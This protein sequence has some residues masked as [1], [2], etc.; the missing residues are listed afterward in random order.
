MTQ[1]F[2]LKLHNPQQSE[3]TDLNHL[4]LSCQLCYVQWVCCNCWCIINIIMVYNTLLLHVTRVRLTRE[5]LAQEVNMWSDHHVAA[6]FGY[7]YNSKVQMSLWKPN[8]LC[9]M[10]DCGPSPPCS[11]SLQTC[12][13]FSVPTCVSVSDWV[14]LT[15]C[16]S[17]RASSVSGKYLTGQVAKSTRRQIE[18]RPA[19]EWEGGGELGSGR[20]RK[21]QQC[22]VK[23]KTETDNRA[24]ISQRRQR[25]SKRDCW[26]VQFDKMLRRRSLSFGGF[27]WY[28]AFFVCVRVTVGNMYAHPVIVHIIICEFE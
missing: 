26:E 15:G 6:C 8:T 5:H 21:A 11:S 24:Y 13:Y 7:K 16:E 19:R 20:D 2:T 22:I 18:T 10:V 27:G 12:V 14:C 4:A 3:K 23:R 17:Q 25:Q 28:V 1:N 9:Q